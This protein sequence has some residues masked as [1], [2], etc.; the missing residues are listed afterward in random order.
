MF[1]PGRAERASGNQP[2]WQGGPRELPERTRAARASSAASEHYPERVNSGP[3]SPPADSVPGGVVPPSHA[4]RP[5]KPGTLTGAPSRRRGKELRTIQVRS[6]RVVLALTVL[7]LAPGCGVLRSAAE[8]PSKVAGAVTGNK[9]P[10]PPDPDAEQRE[11]MRLADLT[12]TGIRAATREFAAQV[13][14]PEAQ[15][16]ALSW[17]L[18]VS[19]RVIELATRSDPVASLLEMIL[20]LRLQRVAIERHYIPEVWGEAALPIAESCL[21]LE[22]DMWASGERLVDAARIAEA[23]H[24]VDEWEASLEG[25]DTLAV[26]RPPSIVELLEERGTSSGSGLLRMITLD[27]F[28]GLEPAARE[29]ALARL[30]AERTLFYAQNVPRLLGDEFELAALNLRRQPETLQVLGSIERITAASESFGKLADDLPQTLR[31]EREDALRQVSEELDAQRRGLLSDL[32]EAEEPLDELLGSSRAT[33]EASERAA[34]QLT[35]LV[36][37]VEA[38]L[39]GFESDEAESSPVASESE[40]AP[41]RPFDINEYTAAAE[42]LSGTARELTEL[43]AQLDASL[44]QVGQ[45]IDTALQR[46]ERSIDQAALRALQV[47]L[48]LIVAAALAVLLVR[49]MRRGP[50]LQD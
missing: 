39:A 1:T 14:T 41:A 3:A 36:A 5:G 48:A 43:V 6:P 44:P 15:I 13:D 25:A 4:W 16:Q 8:A 19:R 49:R 10:K 24:A 31:R 38:L 45:V 37:A 12:V 35:V 42:Q 2:R 30:Y 26:L 11:V 27:P 9:A 34:A 40:T 23:R 21:A 29:V 7:L 47:G 20:A 33:L 32:E 50:E 28:A 17:H 22:E 18:D 46:G